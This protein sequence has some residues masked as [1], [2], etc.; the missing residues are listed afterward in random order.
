MVFIY[1]KIEMIHSLKESKVEKVISK[2]DV[3]L[4]KLLEKK[5]IRTYP[6]NFRV[7]SSNYDPIICWNH[8]C[9]IVALNYQTSD[10]PMQLNRGRFRD[11][12]KCGY[13]LRP[14]FFQPEAE[15]E[16]KLKALSVSARK[17]AEKRALKK[18]RDKMQAKKKAERRAARKASRSVA[19][20]TS[21]MQ[22]KK[23]KKLGATEEVYDIRIIC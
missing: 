12:G 16:A 15:K 3:L 8:G 9:Q 13:L 22:L 20:F 21:K 17:K 1:I 18:E 14:P 10:L 23:T 7:D 6:D 19:M 4:I 2:N 5:L 11:N